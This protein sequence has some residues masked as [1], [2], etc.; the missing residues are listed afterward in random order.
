MTD[1]IG[2]YAYDLTQLH[3]PRF[4]ERAALGDPSG[5]WRSTSRWFRASHHKYLVVELARHVVGYT[6]PAWI[7]VPDDRKVQDHTGAQRAQI[8]EP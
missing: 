7:D 4:S 2:C 1:S 6:R 3:L 5:W 8:H